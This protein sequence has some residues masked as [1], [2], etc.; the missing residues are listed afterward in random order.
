VPS[1]FGMIR[2]A[3]GAA[4]RSA[5]S[6]RQSLAI[7]AK[8]LFAIC[9]TD[10]PRLCTRLLRTFWGL[11]DCS[12]HF[13]KL[14]MYDA[15]DSAHFEFHRDA[16][17]NER[18]VATLVISLESPDCRGG[19][20]VFKDFGE[21]DLMKP[22]REYQ[23]E[24]MLKLYIFYTDTEH[25]VEPVTR[26]YRI[27]LQYEII[28]DDESGERVE[29]V[30]KDKFHYDTDMTG[31]FGGVNSS[32]LDIDNEPQSPIE[33]RSIDLFSEQE[34]DE[35]CAEHIVTWIKNASV[36]HIP[37]LM[38]SNLYPIV[39]IEPDTLKGFDR[40]MYKILNPHFE[41]EFMPVSLFADKDKVSTCF[42]MHRSRAHHEKRDLCLYVTPTPV[43]CTDSLHGQYMGGSDKPAPHLNYTAVAMILNKTTKI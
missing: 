7:P 9:D 15:E 17:H 31:L 42:S 18:H 13:Y 35:S 39:N 30:E 8:S 5:P 36:T 23:L 11:D 24:D 3:S 33:L 32:V 27:L 19:R 12:L 16:V 21:D 28:V 40:L 1:C 37:A 34:V 43:H 29:I 2:D 26:G 25:R 22:S 10:L 14:L 6:L 38:M 41:I 4:A 20:V